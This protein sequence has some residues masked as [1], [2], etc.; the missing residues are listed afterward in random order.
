MCAREEVGRTE[1]RSQ[2]H[3]IFMIIFMLKNDLLLIKTFL[4]NMYTVGKYRTAGLIPR[5]PLLSL[6]MRPLMV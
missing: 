6:G 2:T 4:Q 5:L 3:F 1:V